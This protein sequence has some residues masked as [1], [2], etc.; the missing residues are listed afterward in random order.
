MLV[1]YLKLVI[2]LVGIP[3]SIINTVLLPTEVV[4]LVAGTLTAA[5]SPV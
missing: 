2:C 1:Y 5:Q 3:S 4:T